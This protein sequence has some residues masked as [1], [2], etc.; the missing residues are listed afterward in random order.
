MSGIPAGE[1]ANVRDD[2]GAVV[3]S[4]RSFASVVG[5]IA[6]LVAGVVVV[7]GG[8]GVLF[9]LMEGRPIPAAIALV[10]SA[11]FAVIIILLVPPISVAIY[12]GPDPALTIAQQSNV[13]FPVATYV[14][15]TLDGKALARL[16]KSFFARL[17]RN[18]WTILPLTD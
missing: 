5:I 3:L 10:L 11:G 4:Y 16:R 9:L 14:V 2:S 7:A 8:A 15:A 1:T 18:R 17:G 13:S 6:A 12:D